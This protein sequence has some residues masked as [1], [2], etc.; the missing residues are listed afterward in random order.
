MHIKYYGEL[1]AVCTALSWSI[2]I[3]PFT[4]AAKKVT[5]KIATKNVTK[6]EKTK[7]ICI[8]N[9]SSQKK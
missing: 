4:E 9:V 7:V 2:G 1:I 5:K 6:T 3:F 8:S